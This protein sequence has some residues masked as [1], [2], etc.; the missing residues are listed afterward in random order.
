MPFRASDLRGSP[1]NCCVS[2]DSRMHTMPAAKPTALPLRS[3][4]DARPHNGPAMDLRCR[5]VNAHNHSVIVGVFQ[6]TVP[7][8]L[9]FGRTRLGPSPSS[10]AMSQPNSAALLPGLASQL[11]THGLQPRL[12]S[13][14]FG[15]AAKPD[16]LAGRS[17]IS[18]PVGRYE[19]GR[20]AHLWRDRGTKSLIGSVLEAG[21]AL[22]QATGERARCCPRSDQA[23]V[24]WHLPARATDWRAECLPRS[25]GAGRA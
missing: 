5:F 14:R 2:I 22:R 21:T 1:C 20:T 4:L 11:A 3:T 9:N 8:I 24:P 18:G 7:A 16:C 12:G 23:P 13:S 19:K 10:S 25:A 15:G 6:R 17:Q